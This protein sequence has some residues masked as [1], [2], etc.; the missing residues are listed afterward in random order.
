MKTVYE[1]AGNPHMHTPYSDGELY[2]ADI[3][4]AAVAAGLDFVIVTDHNVRV[5]GVEGY[6]YDDKSGRR[7]LLLVG[8]EVHDPRRSP[9]ANHMLVY[10]AEGGL[11]PYAPHP[12]GLIDEVNGR[13]ASSYLAH[14]VDPAAPEFG[15]DSLAWLD[16]DIRGYTGIELWNYMSEFKS[17]LSSRANGWRVAMNPERAISGPFPETLALWDKLLREGS[18]VRVI[19]GADAHG[20]TYAAGPFKRIV[21]SYEY[22]FRCVNTHVLTTMPLNGDFERDKQLVLNALRDG[23]AFVGYDLP[24]STRGFQF[25]AQ[26]HNTSAVMGDWLRLGHG[27]TLQIVL[28]R[29]AQMRLI[30]DGEVLLDEFEG[31]HRTFIA[32][33]TGAYRVEAYLPFHGK[34]RG[35]IFSN[36]IFIVD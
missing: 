26:G 18:R 16:W 5:A 30:R 10:G 1:Y 11:A 9:Q 22:L 21:F 3:A 27:V 34:K 29:P 4:K 25:I 23:L 28:P 31:T 13:Q 8:E 33:Q 36:P 12:Q 15:E 6:H 2:H 20:H 19:G 17:H 7:V 14:P 24:A 35:W 32:N